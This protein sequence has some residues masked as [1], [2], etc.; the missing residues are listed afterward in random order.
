MPEVLGR[1]DGQTD[2][3]YDYEQQDEFWVLR[4]KFKRS[5]YVLAD[6][7]S[8]GPDEIR[9]TAGLPA[10]LAFVDGAYAKSHKCKESQTCIHPTTGATTILWEV[11]INF[12][13]E[14]DPSNA[15]ILIPEN[16]PPTIR[17]TGENEDVVLEYDAVTGAAIVTAAGEPILI[18]SKSVSPILEIKR[19]EAYPFSPLVM[20]G[21]ANTINATSFWGAAAGTALMLP[22]EVDEETVGNIR[23]AVV[24]Y[25]IQFR[26]RPGLVEPWKA[27][28]LHHGYLARPAAGQ[29]GVVQKD[30]NDN[31]ITVNLNSDGTKL[32]EGDPEQYL[33]FNR[34]LFSNFNDLS[35]GPF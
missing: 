1:I 2:A 10:P 25:R 8:D 19:Y 15:E 33:E 21:Y 3:T 32:P 16:K 20:L 29:P 4:K 26:L 18:E 6:T 13:T 14:F 28:P 17:W 31:P 22:M 7:D 27:R 23:Y 9:D 35:L 24:T 30:K 5:Y 12:D 11:E 34:Y